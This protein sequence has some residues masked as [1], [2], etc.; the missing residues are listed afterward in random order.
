MFGFGKEDR[1]VNQIAGSINGAEE[2]F[3]KAVAL[4]EVLTRP[5][6]VED[7]YHE[8]IRFA[9]M[10]GF[11]D[12]IGQAHNASMEITMKAVVVYILQF[13]NCAA[14]M[15]RIKIISKDPRYLN[16][17]AMGGRA[18]TEIANAKDFLPPMMKLA[19]A[20]FDA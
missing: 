1:L 20:Y 5:K 15:S 11:A 6:T 10:L 3:T 9:I 18:I 2:M 4:T 7:I 12:A 8:N 14:D 13:G 16:W 19:K 17:Q